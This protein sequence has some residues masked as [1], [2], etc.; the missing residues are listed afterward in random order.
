VYVNNI[1]SNN[2]FIY[3]CLIFEAELREGV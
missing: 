3:N 1:N 2:I